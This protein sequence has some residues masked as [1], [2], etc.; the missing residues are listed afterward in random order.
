[1][2]WGAAPC[3]SLYRKEEKKID[4]KAENFY[5]EDQTRT[6]PNKF[7]LIFVKYNQKGRNTE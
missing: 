6:S 3:V 4:R 1:M 5:R 2:S 7:I